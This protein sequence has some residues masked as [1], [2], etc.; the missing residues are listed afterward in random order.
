MASSMRR[1]AV[2]FALFA[3]GL[4]ACGGGE[5]AKPEGRGT[6]APTT[7]PHP[8][9]D[10]EDLALARSAAL[11]DAD[12]PEGWEMAAEAEDTGSFGVGFE[13]LGSSCTEL[14]E[15]VAAVRKKTGTPA[16]VSR[17]FRPA[18]SEER[19]LQTT[20]MVFRNVSGAKSAFSLMLGDN[21]LQCLMQ[22]SPVAAAEDGS[23]GAEFRRVTFDRGAA[24][25]AGGLIIRTP[26]VVD[27]RVLTE[28]TDVAV[29]RE[30]RVI[31]VLVGFAVNEVAPFP[32]FE[33]VVEHAIRRT[34]SA[35]K[36]G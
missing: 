13:E 36:S 5:E 26:V 4:S 24:D 16:D 11:T 1:V 33:N 15:E 9:A 14:Q 27:E 10:P 22:T 12:A 3:L 32:H 23:T 34:V 6:T 20:S 28:E 25:D 31:H 35:A 17:V 30:G 8:A 7:T 19:G 18:K 2:V 29:V 21:V